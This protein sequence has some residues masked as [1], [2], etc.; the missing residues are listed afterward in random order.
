MT[1]RYCESVWTAIR[2]GLRVGLG[3][4]WRFEVPSG[5]LGDRLVILQAISGVSG[6]V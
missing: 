4:A 6:F 5:I 3:D 2:S 1:G